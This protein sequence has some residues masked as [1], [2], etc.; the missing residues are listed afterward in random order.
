MGLAISRPRIG[1]IGGGMI[2]Q[3]AHLPFYLRNDACDVVCVAEERP[4]LRSAL[5]K[6]LGPNRVVARRQEVLQRDD[7]DAVILS[8]PRAATGPLTL[9]AF[10]AGKHIFVE[11]PMAHSVEQAEQL[12]AAAG[13]LTYAVGF[14]KRHDPGVQAAKRLFDEVMKTG[15]FGRLLFARFYDYSKAYAMPMP[16]HVRPTDSRAERYPTWPTVPSW[17]AA[18]WHSTYEWFLNSASHD[19]NLIDY[20]F[21][22]TVEAIAAQASV[23]SALSASLRWQDTPIVLEIARAELGHWHEGAE[24]V[25]ERGRIVLSIPSPMAIDAV[26]GVFIDD[27]TV[28]LKGEPLATGSGWC[29]ARQADAFVAALA[30]GDAMPTAGGQALADMKLTEAIWRLVKE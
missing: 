25:F 19:V 10:A 14:M 17:L 20:F 12:V 7:I 24:F 27:V 13:G 30:G 21:S 16:A 28:G 4:S 22:P 5:S 1:F 8:S 2:A 9:E 6:Q 11:K 18:R 23:N 3:V 15:R 26:S 29:F